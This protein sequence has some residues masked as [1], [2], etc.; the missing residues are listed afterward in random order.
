MRSMEPANE[1]NYMYLQYQDACN[2]YMWKRA[3][4]AARCQLLLDAAMDRELQ[5]H[6]A[7]RDYQRHLNM[8]EGRKRRMESQG[9][10]AE[11]RLGSEMTCGR[12]AHVIVNRSKR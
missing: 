8:E 10:R 11:T 3:E 4:R 2:I 12:A 6:E 1:K 5:N 9:N 7:M